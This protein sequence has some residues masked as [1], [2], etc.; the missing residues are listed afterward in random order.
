MKWVHIVTVTVLA[1]RGYTPRKVD[2]KWL[3]I[4]ASKRYKK[5]AEARCVEYVKEGYGERIDKFKL[6]IEV[7]S[8]SYVVDALHVEEGLFDE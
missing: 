1:P 5:K 7:S 3:A 2:H 4:S 6:I 8:V